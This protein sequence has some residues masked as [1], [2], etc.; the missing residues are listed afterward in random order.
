MILDDVKKY[1]G[2]SY[3]F[4]RETKMSHNCWRYWGKIG[5]IPFDSQMRL[6]MLTDNKLMSSLD[7]YA[8]RVKDDVE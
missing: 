4:E 2:T 8:L 6:Q 1:Y 5:Y 3:V 7:H